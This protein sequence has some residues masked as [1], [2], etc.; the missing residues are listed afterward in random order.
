MARFRGMTRERPPNRRRTSQIKPTRGPLNTSCTSCSRA[1]VTFVES[2]SHRRPLQ[3]GTFRHVRKQQ[4]L[5]AAVQ[6]RSSLDLSLAYHGFRDYPLYALS[7]HWI[8]FPVYLGSIRCPEQDRGESISDRQ[9]Y[10]FPRRSAE[11][12]LL[13]ENLH[14]ESGCPF[15]ARA[16]GHGTDQSVTWERALPAQLPLR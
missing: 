10:T 2:L 3:C 12:R 13:E 6:F 15:V 1:A 4:L 9:C 11:L 8:S 5:R 14:W 16:P 7:S